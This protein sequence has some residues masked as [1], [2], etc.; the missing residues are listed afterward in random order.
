MNS[1]SYFVQTKV[2]FSKIAR[3]SIR[4]KVWKFILFAAII[5]T[6]VALV[7]SKNMFETFEQTKSGFFTLASACIW[8]GIFN[9]IQTICKERSIIKYEHRTGLHM[10]SY[11]LSHVIY[12]AV[13]CLIQ[14]IVMLIIC[15]IY[16][17]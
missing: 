5:A 3:I 9:S 16:I 8:L 13:I 17:K 4:E 14:S 12:Q 15:S 7:T 2:Y 1:A 10:S 11:V 6:I